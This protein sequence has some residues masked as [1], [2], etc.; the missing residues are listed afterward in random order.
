[1]T[2]DQLAILVILRCL[3][4]ESILAQRERFK[5]CTILK[6]FTKNKFYMTIT[7][8]IML[9]THIWTSFQLLYVNM[10]WRKI[11]RIIILIAQQTN[12][13]VSNQNNSLKKKKKNSTKNKTPVGQKHHVTSREYVQERISLNDNIRLYFPLVMVILYGILFLNFVTRV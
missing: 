6:Y 12:R 11:L 8:F 1:M 4:T 7:E 3:W 13:A 5:Y 10:F 2:N 9:H